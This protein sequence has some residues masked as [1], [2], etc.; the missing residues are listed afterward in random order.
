M[1][2]LLPRARIAAHAVLNV[3]V[4]VAGAARSGRE[5]PRL[6]D[7]AAGPRPG[8]RAAAQILWT[9][10]RAGSSG[11]SAGAGGTFWLRRNRLVGS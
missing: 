3:G 2:Q 4:V 6:R 8:G 1:V 11:R 5:R 9:W 10:I 7:A